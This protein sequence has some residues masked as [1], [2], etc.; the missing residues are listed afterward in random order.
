[1]N[2]LEYKGEQGAIETVDFTRLDCSKEDED[3]AIGREGDS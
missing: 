2:S 1:M 3:Y